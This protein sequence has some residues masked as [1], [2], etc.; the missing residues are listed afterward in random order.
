MSTNSKAIQSISCLVF[1]ALVIA[2]LLSSLNCKT[3]REREAEQ[4][5]LDSLYN[6]STRKVSNPYKP[7]SGVEQYNRQREA[8]GDLN[9]YT[10]PPQPTVPE[11]K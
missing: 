1:S 11:R 4:A 7:P 2:L 9:Q 6:D 8:L 3:R 5:R 10:T